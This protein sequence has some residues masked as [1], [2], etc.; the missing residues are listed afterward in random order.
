MTDKDAFLAFITKILLHICTPEQMQGYLEEFKDTLQTLDDIHFPKPD[1][2]PGKKK[3]HTTYQKP[4]YHYL[5]ELITDDNGFFRHKDMAPGTFLVKYGSLFFTD[6]EA[7]PWFEMDMLK[8]EWE[9]YIPPCL[10]RRIRPMSSTKQIEAK[11]YKVK[12]SW[13]CLDCNW[14]T[15]W[16]LYLKSFVLIDPFLCVPMAEDKAG[17][18]A[19]PADWESI[20]PE[21]LSILKEMKNISKEIKQALENETAIY[22]LRKDIQKL[23]GVWEDASKKREEKNNDTGSEGQ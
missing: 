7:L 9:F 2:Q 17:Y 10:H 3:S 1:V 23:M 5:H 4:K 15:K 19:K 14:R 22:D 20:T 16:S 11:D 6:N 21:E 8:K 12:Y 18:L 13:V